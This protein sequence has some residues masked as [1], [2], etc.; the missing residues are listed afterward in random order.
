MILYL[1]FGVSPNVLKILAF[2]VWRQL[3][4]SLTVLSWKSSCVR[5]NHKLRRIAC[6]FWLKPTFAFAFKEIL[7]KFANIVMLIA[8]TRKHYLVII[9]FK[10]D[11][12]SLL[13]GA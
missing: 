10:D 2:E 4:V 5:A 13:C 11:S 3:S 7:T 1:K 12:P 8:E 6:T 9:A